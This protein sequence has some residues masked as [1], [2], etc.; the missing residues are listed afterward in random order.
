MK[1]VWENLRVSVWH[2]LMNLIIK[3][4]AEV[5]QQKWRNFNID[6]VA[7]LKKNKENTWGYDYFIPAY[8]KS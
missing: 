1:K 3:K 7:F 5:G 6:N 4:A 8:K 2:L